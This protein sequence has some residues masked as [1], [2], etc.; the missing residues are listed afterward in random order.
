MGERINWKR[1]MTKPKWKEKNNTRNR[2]II[3]RLSNLTILILNTR[4]RGFEEILIKER[5]KTDLIN[6][7]I[8]WNLYKFNVNNL[9]GKQTRVIK[10]SG[11]NGSLILLQ[12]T[13]ALRKQYLFIMFYLPCRK[14]TNNI[15]FIIIINSLQLYVVCTLKITVH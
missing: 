6:I 8:A 11:K 13:C 1:D 14:Q 15:A 5:I 4:S 9:V 2:A 7:Y 3:G 12:R 10:T